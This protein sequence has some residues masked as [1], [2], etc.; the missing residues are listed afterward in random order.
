MHYVVVDEENDN[1]Y[2]D[3]FPY[4]A[5]EDNNVEDDYDNDN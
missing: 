4:D 2:D 1:E 5:D 3:D